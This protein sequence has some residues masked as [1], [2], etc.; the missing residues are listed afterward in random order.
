M[1]R[2]SFQARYA[3]AAGIFFLAGY[4]AGW[5][6]TSSAQTAS[7]RSGA[8]ATV[9]SASEG[10]AGALAANAEQRSSMTGAMDERRGRLFAELL[11]LSRGPQT[12][13]RVQEFNLAL[14]QLEPGDMEPA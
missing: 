9:A 2:P 12:L 5:F 7:H 8:G 3:V 13:R 4:G 6:R 11:R 1:K 14:D 10:P